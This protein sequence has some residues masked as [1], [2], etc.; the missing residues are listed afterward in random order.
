MNENN[1]ETEICKGKLGVW[2][3]IAEEKRDFQ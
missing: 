3:E 1:Y 2:V